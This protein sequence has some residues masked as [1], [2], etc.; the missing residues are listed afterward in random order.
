MDPDAEP[1]TPPQYPPPAPAPSTPP[2]AAYPPPA[3]APPPYPYYAAPPPKKDNTVLII[4]VVVVV[5]LVVIPAILA[6]MFFLVW[7][8]IVPNMTQKPTVTFA[9][10][11]TQNG[12]AT[13]VVSQVSNEVLFGL[14]EMTLTVDGQSSGDETLVFDP[15]YATLNVGTGSYRAYYEDSGTLFA[16]DPPDRFT[17][18][19]DGASLPTGHSYA[20]SLKWSLDNSVITTAS[21]TT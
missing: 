3:G 1:V 2:P 6:I 18:T 12:N 17:V 21:W 14:F 5:L 10:V 13:W 11:T 20:L 16:L 15:S 8:P 4:I 7:A 19:G 9:A